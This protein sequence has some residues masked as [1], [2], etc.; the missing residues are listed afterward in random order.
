MSSRPTAEVGQS[1]L[2]WFS[3]FTAFSAL[4]AALLIPQLNAQNEPEIPAITRQ[5][6]TVENNELLRPYIPAYRTSADGRIAMASK[7]M[8]GQSIVFNLLR[9]EVLNEHF[10]DSPAGAEA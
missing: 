7:R 1:L 2:T 3:K 8:N 9:P 5:V 10:N 6:T 4:I